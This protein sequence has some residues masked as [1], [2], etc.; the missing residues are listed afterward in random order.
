MLTYKRQWRKENREKEHGYNRSYYARHAEQR[1][2]DARKRH[3]ANRQRLNEACRVRNKKKYREDPLRFRAAH[4]RSKYGLTPEE[5]KQ[6]VKKQGDRCAI[7]KKP[8]KS[9]G[10]RLA[11]DHC[12]RTNRVR[13]LLCHRCNLALGHLQ[14]SPIILKAALAYLRKHA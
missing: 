6:M 9:Q 4:L 5:Y 12:H 13:A 7:C 10:K 3:S 8:S 14:D 1:R 11:I 2:A